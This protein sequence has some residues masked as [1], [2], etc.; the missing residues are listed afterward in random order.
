MVWIVILIC[1]S[2][3]IMPMIWVKQSPIKRKLLSSEKQLGRMAYL[4]EVSKTRFSRGENRLVSV[5]YEISTT[6][7][8]DD[9]KFCIHRVSNRGEDPSGNL[10]GGQ[11]KSQIKNGTIS[12]SM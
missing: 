9:M 2:F 1:M 10:G 8:E 12:L 7:K 5:C 6:Y 3:A 11:V 4:S